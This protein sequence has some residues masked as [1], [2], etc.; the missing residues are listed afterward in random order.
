[1]QLTNPEHSPKT[2]EFLDEKDDHV[3]LHV[4]LYTPI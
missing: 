1:M 3:H 2:G 4:Y